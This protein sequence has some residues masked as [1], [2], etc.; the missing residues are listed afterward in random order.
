MI[1]IGYQIFITLCYILTNYQSFIFLFQFSSIGMRRSMLAKAPGQLVRMTMVLHIMIC[2]IN[3]EWSQ[4]IAK[5]TI[6]LG[7]KVISHC[8][9]QKYALTIDPA[10]R[11]ANSTQEENGH[12]KPPFLQSKIDKKFDDRDITTGDLFDKYPEYVDKVLRSGYP[13]I[14][15][16]KITQGAKG[17]PRQNE[18]GPKHSTYR[19]KLLL[20]TLAEKGYGKFQ[21]KNQSNALKAK[22]KQAHM[23]VKEDWNNLSSFCKGQLGLL[24]INKDI[25]ECKD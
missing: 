5:S 14:D 23:F 24:C 15:P 2:A 16:I 1:E 6:V 9:K 8:V 12:Q 13:E 7:E 25:W 22:S 17:P 20:W 3:N 21:T 11:E 10:D 19:T 18:G 4:E